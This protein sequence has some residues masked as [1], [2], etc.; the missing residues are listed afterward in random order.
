MSCFFM[1]VHFRRFELSPEL[2]RFL[3]VLKKYRPV[4]TPCFFVTAPAGDGSTFV[5]I[6]FFSPLSSPSRVRPEGR[7]GGFETRPCN[8]GLPN[9]APAAAPAVPVETDTL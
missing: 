2:R 1:I 7:R 9:R 5:H 4:C 3:A 6:M 8:T